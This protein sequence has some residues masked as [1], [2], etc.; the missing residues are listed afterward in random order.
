MA[1]AAAPPPSGGGVW[2]AYGRLVV[3]LRW[4][5]LAGWAAVLA[6]AVLVPAPANESDLQGFASGNPAVAAELRSFELFGFPLVARAA[7][8]QHDSDGLSVY[9]Q[10]E[11]VLRAAALTQGAYDTEILG[12]VPV[13]NTL[14]LFP[15]SRDEGTTVVTYLFTDPRSSFTAQRQAAESFA[16]EHLDDP[17]DAFVGVTGSVP[18]RDAQAEI[19][20]SHLHL[21]EATTVLA[22][23]V[24]VG[25]TFRSLVAPLVTLVAAGCSVALTLALA[26][27][28]GAWLGVPI[29][30]DLRPL[31]VAL[32]LGVVTD[33]SILFLSGMRHRLATGEGG[34]AAATRATGD[35]A[36]IVA[37]AGVT[38]AAGTAVLIVARSALFRGFG[39]G[40]AVTVIVGLLVSLT[41]VPALMGVLGPRVFWPSR[42]HQVPGELGA[43]VRPGRLTQLVTGR[44][45]APATVAATAALLLLAAS[46]L[47][48]LR[49]GLSFVQS[50]PA[51][52]AIAR[53]AA[54]AHEGFAPGILSPT[55]VLLEGEGV[56]A[57]PAALDRLGRT[58]QQQPGVAGVLGPGDL[59]L[60]DDLGVLVTP[61]GNAAR[62]LLVL[63]SAPLGARAIDALSGLQDRLPTLLD[64][65]GVRATEVLVGGDTAL[66]GAVVR[67][68]T[69]DLLRIS[70][71][72]LGV[73]LLMLV[74]FLRAFV[75]PL[76]LLAASVLA[77]CAALGLTVL[78]FQH[79]L[80]HDGL[81]FYVP[82]AA[83]VLLVS[84]GSDYNIFAVGRIWQLGA[85]RP[86]RQA[87]ATAMP[88]STRAITSA[89]LAL[90]ASFGLLALVPLTPFRELAFA[91][92][93]G[94]LLDVLVV[95]A[96]L[97]PSLISMVGPVS[98]WPSRRLRRSERAG[99]RPPSGP[100]EQPEPDAASTASPAP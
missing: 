53:A 62:Y 98:G 11:A 4:A 100:S 51:D 14:G 92:A 31:I 28:L 90:A 6:L 60:P 96:L 72:A 9:A 49:L 63:D 57:D 21:V 87:I 12:A 13:P 85:R 5:V 65:A 43:H 55:E 70:L 32:L 30:D 50:L 59:L 7:L 2:A 1:A 27:W 81:T 54:A 78:V 52:H 74:V 80:G 67:S 93:V 66:S 99:V 19:T 97:V 42:P 79:L 45:S 26:G 34:R 46:P 75:A 44:R 17:D 22:I 36:P 24:I 95:R 40:M 83:A 82:F 23:L 47:L 58:L 20:S 29:P 91:M 3:R 35:F 69:D 33:Y 25:L 68:T 86:L 73:N 18:A 38:V 37:V 16:A 39:P 10:A 8:V 15:G 94:I 41:I 89:G 84:L 77:L 48:D 88:Q 71:A 76:Y 61:D 56:G 64:Q